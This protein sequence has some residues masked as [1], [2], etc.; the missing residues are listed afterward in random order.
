MFALANSSC[1]V[2]PILA[3]LLFLL[4]GMFSLHVSLE[5]IGSVALGVAVFTGMCSHVIF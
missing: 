5:M 4:C 3:L 2:V 1:S